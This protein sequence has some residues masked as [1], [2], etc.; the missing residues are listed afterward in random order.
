MGVVV[1]SFADIERC[2]VALGAS[3]G[4]WRWLK[5]CFVLVG[6][7]Y[8]V[9]AVSVL[10]GDPEHVAALVQTGYSG[11]GD[12]HTSATARSGKR[13]SRQATAYSVRFTGTTGSFTRSR[14][15]A[16]VRSVW[17]AASVFRDNR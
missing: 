15:A 17:R 11:A 1:F 3:L 13:P 8:R 9:K 12:V 16:S 10:E 4:A 6:W 2:G 5:D 14:P 7:S